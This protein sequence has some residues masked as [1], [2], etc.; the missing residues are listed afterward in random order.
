MIYILK[1]RDN[2]FYTNLQSSKVLW[3][4]K[5]IQVCCVASKYQ[6]SLAKIHNCVHDK[7]KFHPIYAT[8][9]AHY[10]KWKHG[11][12]LNA[13]I[14]SAEAPWWLSSR[15]QKLPSTHS[16]NIQSPRTF[17]LPSR[18]SPSIITKSIKT[19]LISLLFPLFRIH[20]PSISLR[21]SK[22]V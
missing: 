11:G 9:W 10:S 19:T 1:V 5:V 6:N 17:A 8:E 4:I 3:I 21:S 16:P 15:I 2:W 18:R 20:H 12:I 13:E 7:P 22:E 14:P